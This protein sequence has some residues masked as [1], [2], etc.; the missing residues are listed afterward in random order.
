M[1]RIEE[2]VGLLK[3][4]EFFTISGL[5]TRLQVSGRTLMRDLNILRDK[6]YPI[7]SDQ[8]RGGGVR[9]HRHWGIGRLFL[10]YHEIIDLLL[11]LAIMEKI[12]SPLF[13]G[14][15]KAI[16]HKISGS[17]PESQR[18]KVQNIRQ[19]ILI[20]DLASESILGNYQTSPESS[21]APL[22]EAFFELRKLH[23]AYEDSEGQ[24]THRIIEPHYLCL[25]WPAWYVFAWDGL[26][27]DVRCFRLDRIS[28]CR[29]EEE[30]FKLR[31][32]KFFLETMEAF[33]YTL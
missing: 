10:N 26:R 27:Q 6:G 8:G 16:R 19:R 9:L 5:A 29:L 15:L 11:S 28:E 24:K 25:N 7:E 12:G 23:I 3:S 31:K 17:F 32:D 33:V 22:Y 18:G 1:D 20:G 13:L 14:N 4:G 21:A 2:L 30:S